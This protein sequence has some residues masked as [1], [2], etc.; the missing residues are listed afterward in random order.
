MMNEISGTNC[1]IVPVKSIEIIECCGKQSHQ[2]FEVCNHFKNL[3]KNTKM[4]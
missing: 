2:K 3:K 4:Q 1:T